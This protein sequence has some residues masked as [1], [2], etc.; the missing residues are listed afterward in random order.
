M[1]I[2]TP[3][4]TEHHTFRQFACT[5]SINTTNFVIREHV[6]HHAEHRVELLW[7]LDKMY[8]P[9]LNKVV[10]C[11]KHIF[12][13]ELSASLESCMNELKGLPHGG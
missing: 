13:V 10:K 5:Y 2:N 12:E 9:I 3:T 7:A 1:L 8:T 6:I 11:G 4:K